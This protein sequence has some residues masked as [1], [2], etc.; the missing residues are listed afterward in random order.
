MI[1]LIRAAVFI[2]NPFHNYMLTK[3]HMLCTSLGFVSLLNRIYRF[4]PASL[5]ASA[6]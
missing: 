4:D 2:K 3:D 6:A 5:E 1:W